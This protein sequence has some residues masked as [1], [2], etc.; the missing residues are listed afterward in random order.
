M[1]LVT[2]PTVEPVSVS[3]MKDDRRITDD[4]EDALCDLYLSAARRAIELRTGL[5]LV[6]QTWE[7]AYDCW[8]TATDLNPWG[9]FVVPRPPLQSVTSIKYIDG[10]GVEQTLAATEY[11]VNTRAF[12]GEIVLAYGKSWPT[13]RAVPNA[14]VIRFVAG[15][16][17][18]PESVPETLRDAIRLEA[19]DRYVYRTDLQ[20]DALVSRGAVQRLLAN[21]MAYV[22]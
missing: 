3:E 1:T 4:P 15:F 12:P 5:A 20:Q 16:G 11:T 18:T 8:P 21:E 13:I 17:A 10:D 2:G 6:T 19:A 14:I 22:V 7:A 9:G